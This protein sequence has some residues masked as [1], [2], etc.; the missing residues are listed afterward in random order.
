MNT[1]HHI[2]ESYRR[3]PI[4][5]LWATY[6]NPFYSIT[7]DL[8][9]TR[10]KAFTDERGYS[11]YVNL[12]YFMTR[13]MRPLEDFRYRLLDGRLVLYDELHPGV[14]LPAP[15][16]L[17]TFAYFE[18]H[19]DVAEFNERARPIFEGAR[20]EVVLSEPRHRNWI[21]FT[22]LP[23]VPFTGFTHATDDPAAGEPQIAFG[24][25]TE[26]GGRLRVPVGL[27]VNHRFIDG[28]ALGELYER[29]RRAFDDPG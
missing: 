28:N 24:K 25:F 26:E 22:A 12:C 9:V 5:D 1:R 14:T 18:Y 13:A 16:G 19:P 15:E 27:Q 20:R 17:F 4:Y 6:R 8:D 29:A 11:V 21:Y 2:V 10:L 3:Q 7:F 23:G